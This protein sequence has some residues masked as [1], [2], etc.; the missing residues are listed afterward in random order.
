MGALIRAV[1]VPL[2]TGIVTVMQLFRVVLLVVAVPLHTG[3]VTRATTNQR[4]DT[5][6]GCSSPTHGDCYVINCTTTK[7]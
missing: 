6:I 4:M 2:H 3:I 7:Q 5:N 1:A